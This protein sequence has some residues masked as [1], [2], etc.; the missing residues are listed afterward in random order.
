MV[1]T[2]PHSTAAKLMPATREEAAR[3]KTAR[4]DSP[5]S[6]KS[7][8]RTRSRR[9]EDFRVD[10]APLNAPLSPRHR[11]AILHGHPPRDPHGNRDDSKCCT[12]YTT[13]SNVMVVINR[14]SLSVSLTIVIERHRLRPHARP[15]I[16]RP[17]HPQRASL[18]KSSQPRL[19]LPSTATWPILAF[20]LDRRFTHPSTM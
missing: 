1:K 8:D 17:P 9:R 3:T 16:V 10:V 13:P 18:S 5:L 15:Q 14:P 11:T 12:I 20:F 7:V 19:S 4:T 2:A 6:D